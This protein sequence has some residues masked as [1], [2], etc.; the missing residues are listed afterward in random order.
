M[1][2]P[3]R[4]EILDNQSGEADRIWGAR[5][6]DADRMASGGKR[7][8]L[9]VDSLNLVMLWR[10]YRRSW[11]IANGAKVVLAPLV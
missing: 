1:Q 9:A 6:Y 3:P 11:K 7:R 5:D 2:I 8:R 10:C 4:A